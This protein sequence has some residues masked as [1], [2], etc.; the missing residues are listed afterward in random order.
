V[1]RDE[2]ASRLHTVSFSPQPNTWA[3]A[4]RP[5]SRKSSTSVELTSAL[6]MMKTQSPAEGCF[7]SR[8]CSI[9]KEVIFKECASENNKCKK[10]MALK[11]K[12]VSKINEFM[13]QLY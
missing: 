1:R 12:L 6:I 7:L 10:E 3:S 5:L 8:D 11:F 9:T 13:R 2:D 4:Q